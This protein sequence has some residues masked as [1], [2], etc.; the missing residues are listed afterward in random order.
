MGEEPINSMAE[1]NAFVNSAKFALE[2]ATSNVQS[3]GWWFNK[4]CTKMI[5]DADGYYTVPADIIDLDIDSNPK[6]LAVRGNRLYNT[7]EGDY[8]LGKQ[9]YRANIIRL[10]DFDDCPFHAKRLI[11]A[12]TVLLFQQSYDG[13]AQKIKEAEQEYSMAYQLA[14]SQHIRA[15][16]ANFGTKAARMAKM[17]GGQIR[18][19][20]PR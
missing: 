3:E 17:N 6:W 18:L 19:R 13:D 7:A 4:E 8:L 9:E 11:K 2:N 1:E 5:P 16:K 20:T 12:M 10:L 15:V 14:K